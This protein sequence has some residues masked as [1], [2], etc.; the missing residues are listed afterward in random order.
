M[1]VPL[2]LLVPAISQAANTIAGCSIFPVNNIWNTPVDTLPIDPNSAAYINTIGAGT[3][4]HADFG[5]GLWN[6]GPIGIPYN[7]V[8][9]SQA[10]VPIRFDY[11]GE[12]DPGPY[13]VPRN[14][15]IEGGAAGD[16][17]RHVLILDK[18]QCRLYE[19]YYAWP[20]PDGS[21]YAGSGAIFDLASHDLRPAGWTSADAAGLPILSGLVRYDEAAGGAIEHAIRF[22]VPKTRKAYIWPARHH[23]SELTG[24]QYPPMG[25]RFRLK[26]NFD[27]SHFS[28]IV[29]TI[30]KAMKKYGIIL[31]DN[32][33]A[34]YINGVPDERWDNDML[35]ELDHVYGS[36]LEA[37]N[38]SS[39][40][41]DPDSGEVKVSTP[42]PSTQGFQLGLFLLLR[43]Q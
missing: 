41:K 31:A 3:P 18:T 36:D 22:T 23:A 27:V 24:T 28:P 14:A 15:L 32:G 13:P 33:S 37:V 20:Q 8:S 42:P 43:Q 2:P 29:Q 19:L 30:L 11:A 7:V 6:N 4:F 1:L 39:L 21:W 34:W 40:M 5:S 12:S 16:G 26:A 9:S 35:H 17:D 38:V 10:K 25:Q